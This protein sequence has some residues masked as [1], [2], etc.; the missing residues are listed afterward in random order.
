MEN[1]KART[2][3]R[4]N[5]E[6]KTICVLSLKQEKLRDKAGIEFTSLFISGHVLS[7]CAIFLNTVV[8]YL[9]TCMHQQVSN[10]WTIAN[11]MLF[12]S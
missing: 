7:T 6:S 1:L 5:L 11:L 4:N 8:S 9:L 12:Y 3:T 2:T 10:T